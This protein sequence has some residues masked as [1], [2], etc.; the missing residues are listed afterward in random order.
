MISRRW[1][2]CAYAC[3]KELSRSR[4]RSGGASGCPGCRSWPRPPS[5]AIATVAAVVLHDRAPATV[6]VEVAQTL[7]TAADAQIRSVDVPVPAGKYRYLSTHAISMGGTNSASALFGNREETWI[8]AGLDDDW[9]RLNTD[10]GERTRLVGDDPMLEIVGEPQRQSAPCGTFDGGESFCTGRGSWQVPTSAFI[11]ELPRD[12]DRLFDL[13]RDAT[14]DRGVDPD[15]EVLVYISDALRRGM[16]PA[17]LRAALCRTLAK[18]P[19][20]RI[21][22]KLATLDGRTGAALGIAAAGERT[23]IV[24]DPRT[25]DFI[26]ERRVLTEEQAGVPAGTVV[27][28]T[29]VRYDVVGAPWE[30]P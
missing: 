15:L 1:G 9:H 12:P 22:E 27:G 7:N 3:W 28:S 4:R 14:E 6:M 2:A 26:G 11:A 23:D 16:L 5:L 24:I 30:R 13:L 8:P 17:D 21:T 10:T 20:L 19:G 25:G 18:L 29:T